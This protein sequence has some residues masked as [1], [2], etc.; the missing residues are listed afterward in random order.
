MMKSRAQP[1]RFVIGQ[2][3]G[4]LLIAGA[5][6]FVQGGHGPAWLW[7]LFAVWQGLLLWQYSRMYRSIRQR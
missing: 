1:A 7:V 6:L 2:Q 4:L 5:V 3:V